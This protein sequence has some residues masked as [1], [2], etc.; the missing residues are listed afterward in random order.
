[1]PDPVDIY[2]KI[3]WENEK[4]VAAYKL[5]MLCREKDNE[6]QILKDKINQMINIVKEEM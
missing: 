1:M 2:E 3:I 5:A 4:N 6:I